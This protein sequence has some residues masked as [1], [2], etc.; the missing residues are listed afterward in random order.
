MANMGCQ[1]DI[2]LGSMLFIILLVNDIGC[3]WDYRSVYMRTWPSLS[4]FQCSCIE[5]FRIVSLSIIPLISLNQIFG[6]NCTSNLAVTLILIFPIMYGCTYLRCIFGRH[7]LYISLFRVNFMIN[8]IISA[9]TTFFGVCASA[10]ILLSWKIHQQR[11]LKFILVTRLLALIFIDIIL[12]RMS[13]PKCAVD[14][15]DPCALSEEQ[16]NF[17][18]TFYRHKI[19]T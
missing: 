13:V 2:T 9:R 4:R 12:K 14:K 19:N 18:R 15:I 3:L 11:E 5:F 7:K 6:V 17:F 1:Y 10:L 8:G 16:C